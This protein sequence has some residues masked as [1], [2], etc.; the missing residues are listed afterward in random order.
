LPSLF[1]CFR[2]NCKTLL[3]WQTGFFLLRLVNPALQDPG[4]IAGLCVDM[5][6][7]ESHAARKN[8]TLL[9]SVLQHLSN[10]QPLK[11]MPSL[12]SWLARA[13]VQLDGLF[14]RI[15]RDPGVP[16][17]FPSKELVWQFRGTGRIA[18]KSLS[19]EDCSFALEC[20]HASR[21]DL[22]ARTQTD[23]NVF[24]VEAL[25]KLLDKASGNVPKS[26]PCKVESQ[27][28]QLMAETPVV[29]GKK[30]F[31]MLFKKASLW[32]RV[33]VRH[34]P[35]GKTI[36]F[37]SSSEPTESAVR[38]ISLHMLRGCYARE[39]KDVLELETTE[40]SIVLGFK[41]CKDQLKV[42]QSVLNDWISF[43]HTSGSAALQ[44]G[45]NVK[46]LKG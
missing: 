5:D 17:G 16:L 30:T 42:W 19:A 3:L 36:E 1:C 13:S 26:E 21:A 37:F 44:H 6:Q 27:W 45:S 24:A 39:D 18:V 10:D 4:L 15:A 14:R 20:F 25:C 29:T 12:D 22:L 7:T 32:K 46:G 23:A 28:L 43:L 33:H 9:A 41:E 8:L 35:D 34:S 40:E 31:K 38:V 2:I 11:N